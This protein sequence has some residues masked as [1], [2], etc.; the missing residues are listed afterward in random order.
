[1]NKNGVTVDR[2][3]H[4][5]KLENMFRKGMAINTIR[6]M[7]ERENAAGAFF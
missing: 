7:D 3:E 5:R 6:D 1:L 2:P 4:P